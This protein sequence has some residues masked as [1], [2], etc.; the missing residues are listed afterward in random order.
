MAE[1]YGL[2]SGCI[3]QI[4][5]YRMGANGYSRNVICL[6]TKMRALLRFPDLEQTVGKQPDPTHHQR[7]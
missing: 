1:N 3:V 5:G 2:I 7:H 6:R 4:R